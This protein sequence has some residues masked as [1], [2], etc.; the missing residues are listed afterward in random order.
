MEKFAGEKIHDLNMYG[1]DW[2]AD[3]L[4]SI[5]PWESIIPRIH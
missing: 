4:G 2:L 3:K 5:N 1:S